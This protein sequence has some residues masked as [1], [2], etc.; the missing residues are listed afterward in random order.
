MEMMFNN[1]QEVDLLLNSLKP[2]DIVLEWGSGGSTLEI[3]KRV[4]Y[5][6][7]IEHDHKW[8]NKVLSQLPT[9][10]YLYHIERNKE[11]AS[12]HDGTFEDYEDYIQ[13]PLESFS[14]KTFD[15]IFI[16]GR[17][18]SHCAKAAWTL[19]KED[20]VIFI[21]DYRHPQ[22]Q[23]RRYEYEVVEEFLEPIEGAFA[24]WKFKKKN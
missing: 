13:W 17:A 11:E 24:L 10:A 8:Y 6:C 2:T 20:G 5:L 9:N 14:P 1:Q 7:S 23:Y 15:V 3:A 22:E 21:H 19:L 12:G 4:R 18:R 16:D